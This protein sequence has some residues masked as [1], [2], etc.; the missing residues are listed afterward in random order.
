LDL[1]AAADGKRCAGAGVDDYTK[2]GAIDT[3]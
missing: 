3:G 2:F 1:R